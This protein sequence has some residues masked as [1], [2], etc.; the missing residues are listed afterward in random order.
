MR[1]MTRGFPAL[2]RAE[3]FSVLGLVVFTW[4]VGG[5]G[6]ASD[7]RL[8]GP[9]LGQ[10]PPGTTPRTFAPGFV[11]TPAHEFGASFT[12]DGKA[13]YFTRRDPNR[14]A[15]VIMMSTCIDDIWT[16]P[17]VAPFID[18]WEAFEPRVTPDGRRLYFTSNKPL[19]LEGAVPMSM[20]YVERRGKGW[21]SPENAGPPF[22][23]MKSMYVSMTLD[24]TIYTTDISGGPGTEGIAV[25]RQTGGKYRKLERLGPPINTGTTDMYPFVAPD[26]SYLIFTSRRPP[27]NT[28]GGGLW[29]AFKKPDGT[30]TNP[31]LIDLGMEAGLPLVSPDGKYLFFTAGERGKSDIYWVEAKFI[32]LLK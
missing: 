12:P 3:V 9:Y 26:E 25:A 1:L 16:E 30:W 31:R 6:S 24:G 13:F 10:T 20:W 7:K 19:P 2:G 8:Q 11:S 18:D 5:A 14:N 27:T 22:N 21:T 32:E 4:A 17:K 23:P 28:R 29:I 15:N